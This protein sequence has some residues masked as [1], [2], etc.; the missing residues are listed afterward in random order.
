MELGARYSVPTTAKVTQNENRAIQ[1]T[2]SASRIEVSGARV[3]RG[4]VLVR[5]GD[6]QAV[7][8]VTSHREWL[9]AELPKLRDGK[10][11]PD[12]IELA[13]AVCFALGDFACT[14]ALT[15]RRTANATVVPYVLMKSQHA[16]ES[17][18]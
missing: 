18:P 7:R 4:R 14:H 16:A 6:E 11:S 13:Y 8:V 5:K 3:G 2:K 1:L 17:K 9:D 12:E 15:P 10:G